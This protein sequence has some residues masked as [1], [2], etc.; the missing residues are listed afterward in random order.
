[1]RKLQAIIK[2]LNL[3]LYAGYSFLQGPSTCMVRPHPAVWRIIHG[4]VILYM[5]ALVFLLFQNADD[6]RLL[7]KVL[8]L[9]VLH[10]AKV[11][12]LDPMVPL[13]VGLHGSSCTLMFPPKPTAE[14][15]VA[16][17]KYLSAPQRLAA[18]KEKDG[19][20]LL[21]SCCSMRLPVA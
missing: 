4:I 17:H 3:Y 13:I 8:Q 14:A 7:L 5:L 9:P 12:Q 2:Q 1:M 18:W 16:L 20:S 15:S 19:M 21:L 11:L 10:P 6:A